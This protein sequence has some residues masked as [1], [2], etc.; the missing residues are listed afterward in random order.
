M[1]SIKQIALMN[2]ETQKHNQKHNH[3]LRLIGFDCY[4]K[5]WCTTVY[6]HTKLHGL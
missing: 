1:E 3:V 6:N 5:P 2:M 4:G